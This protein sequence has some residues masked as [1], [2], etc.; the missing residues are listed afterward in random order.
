MHCFLQMPVAVSDF[1]P[2]PAAG[3]ALPE[4]PSSL[5]HRSAAFSKFA[6]FCHV[7]CKGHAKK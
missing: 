4:A 5:L 1:I 2:A 3:A 7:F 6:R